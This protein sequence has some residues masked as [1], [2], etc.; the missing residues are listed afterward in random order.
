MGGDFSRRLAYVSFR[1]LYYQRCGCPIIEPY[2]WAN[3]RPKPCHTLVYDTQSPGIERVSIKGTEPQ[4]N[5]HGGYHDAGDSDRNAYQLMVP[6]VLLTTYEVFPGLFT[7]DQFNIPDRFDG[8]FNIVGKG[9]GVPDILDEAAWGTM[10]WGFTKW[11]S[12]P[13]IRAWFS[14]RPFTR[15]CRKAAGGSQRRTHS[16]VN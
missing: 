1:S 15:S 5:V 3:I 7:D 2:A 16:S 14:R 8:D 12:L 11:M 6:I 9:N 13:F 10:L 4:L